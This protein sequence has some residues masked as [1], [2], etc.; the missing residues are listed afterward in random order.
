MPPKFAWPSALCTNVIDC[1]WHDW[2][3]FREVICADEAS[4]RPRLAP[5]RCAGFSYNRIAKEAT[6]PGG[7]RVAPQNSEGSPPGRPFVVYN[8][9]AWLQQR[10][11]AEESKCQREGLQMPQCPLN[12]VH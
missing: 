9:I 6:S 2:W 11:R 3:A 1:L 8:C 7:W 12:H 4:K 10:A 5:Y